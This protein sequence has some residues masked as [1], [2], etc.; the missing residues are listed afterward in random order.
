M[1]LGPFPAALASL[2]DRSGALPSHYKLQDRIV[3]VGQ[4]RRLSTLNGDIHRSA[5]EQPQVV[6]RNQSFT[7]AH[8]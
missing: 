6:W 2:H 3:A 7:R 4:R 1:D 5:R 8:P